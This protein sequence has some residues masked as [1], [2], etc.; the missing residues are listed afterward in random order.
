MIASGHGVDTVQRAYSYLRFSSAR[1]AAGD[2]RRR[3]AAFA[4][5]LC[6][7][8]G[9]ILDDSLH[10]EDLGVSAFRGKNAEVGSLSVFRE[11]VR[12]GR[13]A[14]G[15]I[16]IVESLDRLSRDAVDEAYDLFRGII[17]AGI[18]IATRTPERVYNQEA[19]GG[20]M[21]ALL[22]PLFIMSR[23]AEESETKSVRLR[24]VW[25]RKKERAASE[26]KPHTAMSPAWIKLT[27][28]GYCLIP[29][30]AKTVRA[31][32]QMARDGLGIPRILQTLVDDPERYPPFGLKGEWNR[33]YVHKILTSRSLI[34]EYQPRAVDRVTGKKVNQGDAIPSYYP[35]VLTEAEW[36]LM[37]KSVQRRFRRTGRLCKG[38][39]NL[40]TGIVFSA[41]TKDSM[42]YWLKVITGRD[43]LK[44]YASA[45]GIRNGRNNRFA[46]T[47]SYPVFEEAVLNCISELTPADLQDRGRGG[48]DEEAIRSETETI[49][50]LDHKLTTLKEKAANP[51]TKPAALPAI[52][53]LIEETSEAKQET[54]RRLEALK[55]DAVSGRPETLGEAQSLVKLLAKAKGKDAEAL[56]HRLK[57]QLRLLID[58]IWIVVERLSHKLRA[59]HIQICYRGGK[60]KYV[61]TFSP[62]RPANGVLPPLLPLWN[63]DFRTLDPTDPYGPLAGFVKVDEDVLKAL[64]RFVYSPGSK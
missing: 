22:E 39:L 44:S 30:R 12:S 53:E 41:V 2:S 19:C 23:A 14:P 31:I 9:W 58:E 43:Y 17:R 46:W 10:L 34:G 54:A 38:R 50:A 51:K 42:H 36:L 63:V 45:K 55:A 28:D 26:G 27:P 48:A 4:A 60:T 7:R 62:A 18:T 13:V 49:I 15:S 5:E 3:Q 8:N 64:E 21:L 20:D 33:S 32:C 56:R 35:A 11:A 37:R 25:G 6:Q 61:L 47:A 57:N 40:F 24:A 52:L 29:D 16:L 59:I 1:Q